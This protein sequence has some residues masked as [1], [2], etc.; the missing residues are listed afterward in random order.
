VSAII[1]ACNWS[2]RSKRQRRAEKVGHGA[3]DS[4]ILAGVTRREGRAF[5]ALHPALDIDV[6]AMLLA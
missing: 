1:A 3:E 5:A 6:G 2:K 4:P